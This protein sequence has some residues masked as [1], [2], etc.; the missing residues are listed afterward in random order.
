MTVIKKALILLVVLALAAVLAVAPSGTPTTTAWAQGGPPEAPP[1][2]DLAAALKSANSPDLTTRAQGLSQL[3]QIYGGTNDESVLKQA[4]AVL[5]EAVIHGETASIRQAAVGAMSGRSDRPVT[6]AALLQATYDRDPEVQTAALAPLVRA[7]ASKEVDARL[8]QLAGSSDPAVAAAAAAALMMRYGNLGA[9]GA[10]ELVG[11]LGIDHA[12][13]N[14]GAALQLIKVGRAGMPDLMQ[15]LASSPNPTERHGAAV[16]ISMI[17]GG[18]SDREEAFAKAAQA[19]YKIKAVLP[20]PDLRPL[21]VLS[22]RLLHDSDELTR[23]A[24]AQA[25]GYLANAQAAPALAAALLSDADAHVR[26]DAASAL[27]LTPGTGAVPALVTA[28]EKDKDARV[29][30]FSAEALGWTGDARAVDALVVATQDSNEEVRRLAATELGRLKSPAALEALTALFR[31]PSEDVRWD[32]VRAVD[33]LRSHAAVPAL[34]QAANDPSVLVSHAAETA[35]QKMG[36][37]MREE[38]NLK[39]P[40]EST[41][42][43]IATPGR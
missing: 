14:G 4:E 9:A 25:L 35:L 32:A 34:V 42:P 12:D 43:A 6:A 29:R 23:E 8:E 7:P 28:V 5:R 19:T 16:V 41:Q 3:G 40:A 27:V 33:S 24:C 36:E 31:D 1:L 30:R 22:D 17:C 37:V 13:A 2:P 38:P 26:A 11:A 20:D 18:K 21:G 10:P 39:Q 15:A